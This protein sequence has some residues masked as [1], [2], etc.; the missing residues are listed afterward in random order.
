MGQSLRE[1]NYCP[2]VWGTYAVPVYY[3]SLQLCGLNNLKTHLRY[4][5]N[6]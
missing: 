6:R 4:V 2:S 1:F 3:L 5:I